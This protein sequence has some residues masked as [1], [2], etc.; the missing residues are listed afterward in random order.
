MKTNHL[1]KK[2]AKDLVAIIRQERMSVGTKLVVSRLAN[3]LGI[4]RTPVKAA[5]ETLVED[6]V[7]QYDLNKGFTLL[8][9][10]EDF[11]ILQEKFRD[12][13]V[14][15][16]YEA[17]ADSHLR[18]HLGDISEAEMM[19]RFNVSRTLLLKCLSRII[20]EGWVERNE[21]HGWVF[22]E[23]VDSAEAYEES[24]Y[25]RMVNEPAAILC[26]GF[27]PD[28]DELK[29]LK[30]EQEYIL[31][32]GF[33][34][35]TRRE[36]YDAN[37]RFHEALVLWSGN[38][39]MLHAI[40]RLNQLRRIVEYRANENARSRVTQSKE[41][42]DILDYIQKQDYLQAAALMKRHIERARKVKAYDEK[43]FH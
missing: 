16:L 25:F 15:V 34:K 42:I 43:V 41:H 36:L 14:E 12:N 18:E 31:Q 8:K 33:D 20:Q 24:Y 38:R 23:I 7:V 40:K 39:F 6:G 1:Q 3:S 21:G 10:Y 27:S 37:K 22:Q 19:R 11:E 26:I 30:E 28:M 4:S 9:S 2:A 13:E 17:I 29:K 5:L 32:H 35:M